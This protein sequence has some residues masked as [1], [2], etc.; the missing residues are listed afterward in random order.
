M[1]LDDDASC[2]IMDVGSGYL[3]AGM[4]DDDGPK[5]YIPMV[6]GIPKSPDIMAGM[7]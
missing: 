1:M 6:C 4:A 3:K 2:I 5:Y 7:D